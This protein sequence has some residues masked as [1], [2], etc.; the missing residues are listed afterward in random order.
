MFTIKKILTK[1]HRKTVKNFTAKFLDVLLSY[2][3]VLN[4]SFANYSTGVF[5]KYENHEKRLG[6]EYE[7]ENLL[8]L[9]RPAHHKVPFIVNC[10]EHR[11][12]QKFGRFVI[13]TEKLHPGAII[14][15]EKPLMKFVDLKMLNLIKPQSGEASKNFLCKA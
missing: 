6:I 11:E 1:T 3:A 5:E 14:A 7:N 2:N 13:T 8:K 15:V 12:N 10:L 4:E 9:S